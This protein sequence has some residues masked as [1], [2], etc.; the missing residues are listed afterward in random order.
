MEIE[1][2]S[3]DVTET[4]SGEEGSGIVSFEESVVVETQERLKKTI[5]GLYE[6]KK[7][8]KSKNQ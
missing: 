6:E 4:I 7:K 2:E 1:H 8:I 3:L 5:L